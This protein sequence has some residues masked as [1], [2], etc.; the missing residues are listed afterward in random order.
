MAATRPCKR[1]S[2]PTRRRSDP[3]C[4]RIQ[5]ARAWGR[6]FP[7]GLKWSF[8][9]KAPGDKYVIINTDESETGTFKDRELCERNPHQIIEGALIAAYAIGAKTIYNYFRGEYM[10]AAY[11]FEEALQEAYAAG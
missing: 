10:D 1:R 11:A 2:P 5:P 7:T 8:I 4:A 9:P 3:N 6:R